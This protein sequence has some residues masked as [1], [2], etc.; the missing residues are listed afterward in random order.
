MY[1]DVKSKKHRWH[2][3]RPRPANF[4]K[5]S[6]MYIS[7][8]WEKMSCCYFNG[9]EIRGQWPSSVIWSHWWLKKIKC[10]ILIRQQFY[11]HLSSKLF[12]RVKICSINTEF[13]IRSFSFHLLNSLPASDVF[14][15]HLSHCDHWMSVVRCVSSVFNNCFKGHLLNYWLDFDQ[16]WHEWSLYGPLE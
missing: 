1:S 6:L 13:R 7:S 5:V 2:Q 11:A 9:N 16:T 4:R 8:H 12:T 3:K 10:C 14:L 15:A